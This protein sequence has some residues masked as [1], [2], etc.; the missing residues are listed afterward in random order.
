M[1]HLYVQINR[2]FVYFVGFTAAPCNHMHETT[3]NN[4]GHSNIGSNNNDNIHEKKKSGIILILADYQM[5]E[6]DSVR[7]RIK[8]DCCTILIL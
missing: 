7:S 5:Y 3:K 6:S 4:N 8:V 2:I 1:L